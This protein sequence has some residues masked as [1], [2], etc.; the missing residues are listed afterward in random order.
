M[1]MKWVLLLS[2]WS[3]VMQVRAEE[4]VVIDSQAVGES[5]AAGKAEV[6]AVT[7][8]DSQADTNAVNKELF[9]KG[10]KMSPR[11]KAAV[12]KAE[13]A[14]TNAQSGANFL[15][16]NKARPGVVSLPSGVQYKILRAGK[17]K[18]PTED[19]IVRCR[20]KGAL[21]DGSIIDRSDENR[22]TSM[23]VAGFL[24]GLKEAVMLMPSG[25]KWQIVIPPQ[26]AY[27]ALGNRGV[28]PNAVLI[29]EME[30]L[31]IK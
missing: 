9:I 27:G 4:P 21:T 3:V 2:L 24:A 6:N 20:F 1:Q 26:L 10:G 5:S 22:P 29:Y 18:K 7:T 13:L 12:A 19:S 16:I 30:I 25:S 15:G 17:G 14:D 28:G 23:H 8:S 31:G 11:E